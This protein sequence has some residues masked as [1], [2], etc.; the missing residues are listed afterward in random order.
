MEHKINLLELNLKENKW[1]PPKIQV[2]DIVISLQEAGIIQGDDYLHILKTEPY[3]DLIYIE[4]NSYG[5]ISQIRRFT[6]HEDYVWNS[7]DEHFFHEH[8][9]KVQRCGYSGQQI[10]DIY[11]IYNE[12]HPEWHI[13]RYLTKGLKVLDHIYNCVR[14]NSAKEMLYKA[15]LDELAARIDEI[16]DL[17]LLAT[18]PT[19]IY[20][21]LTMKVLRSLNCSDGAAL[22]NDQEGR[23]FI[24]ELNIR[25]SDLFSDRL[26]DAQCRYIKDL[27]KE[28]LTLGEVGRLVRSRKPALAK[29]WT[30]SLYEIFMLNEHKKED[31]DVFGGDLADIDPIYGEYFKERKDDD[32]DTWKKL[33]YYLIQNRKEYDRRIRCSNR[34]REY[35]WQERDKDYCIRY[36]QTINDFCREAI[37]MRNCLLGYVEA[38]INND[39]TI[40]FMRKTD[41]VNTPF[42]TIEVYQGELMQ[43]YHRFNDDCDSE[44]AHWIRDYCCRHGISTEKFM[45]DATVDLLM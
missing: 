21:G 11:R 19:E 35:E 1:T 18:K 30:K 16:D 29:V 36:P 39:T 20:S 43:A 14:R 32:D 22:I 7:D 2:D 5:S 27:I 42:V 41:D 4:Q 24:R 6:I 45:F 9:I 34:K 8:C 15:G 17:N 12:K 38:M 31:I 28:D 3:I 44:E 23:D 40:L 10:E 13:K 26:N 33:D 25:F 37:Y